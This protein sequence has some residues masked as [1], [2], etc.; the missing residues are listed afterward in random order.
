M[1]VKK[2]IKLCIDIVTFVVYQNK[3][4]SGHKV[5]KH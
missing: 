1:V 3:K 2:I 4:A 5:V